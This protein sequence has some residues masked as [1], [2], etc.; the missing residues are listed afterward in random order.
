MAFFDRFGRKKHPEA[1]RLPGSGSPAN[2]RFVGVNSKAWWEI[3]GEFPPEALYDP[4]E[5]LGSDFDPMGSYTGIP[6][7]GGEPTQDADDL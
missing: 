6:E 4:I 7:D 3:A 2:Q 5:D 1:R